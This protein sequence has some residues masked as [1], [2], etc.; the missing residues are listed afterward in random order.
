[1]RLLLAATA[2]LAI[3]AFA[4]A[5]TYTYGWEDGVGAVLGSYGNLYN[6]INQSANVNS[7]G[8]ALEMQESPL[9]GTPQAYVAFIENL[10]QGDIIDA[11]FYGYDDTPGTSPSFRIWAHY[12][13]SGDVNSYAGSASGN[14]TYSAG[15][16][17]EQLAWSWSF[18]DGGGTRDAL[19]IEYRLYSDAEFQT[20]DCDDISVTAPDAA[21]VTFPGVDPTATDG[22]TWG[23]VK[24]LFR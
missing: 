21:T 9:G 2:V 17:W 18:D 6:P 24:S 11:S 14:S 8:H 10:T 7:G 4:Q 3:A 20:Y 23:T 16:G 15:I 5:G 1:M 19:V 13:N 22:T 12:A